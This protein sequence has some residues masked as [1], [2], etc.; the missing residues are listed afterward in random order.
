VGVKKKKSIG[1][2]GRGVTTF[3]QKKRKS[4]CLKKRRREKRGRTQKR[5]QFTF[6]DFNE[7]WQFECRGF[8]SGRGRDCN[9]C[10]GLSLEAGNGR[11]GW[12]RKV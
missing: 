12:P 7:R 1:N 11:K 2:R 5:F 8:E 9:T 4:R 6:L 3:S 10:S